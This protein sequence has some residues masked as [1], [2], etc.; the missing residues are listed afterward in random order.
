[1]RAGRVKRSVL[2]EPMVEPVDA[3]AWFAKLDQ[4]LDEPF[5]PEGRCQ[6]LMPPPRKP[7]A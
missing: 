6:P 5:M 2:P 7:F 4:Y 3:S 1:M